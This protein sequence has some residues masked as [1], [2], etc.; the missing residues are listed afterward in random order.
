MI[1]EKYEII[2]KAGGGGG[3]QI[4]QVYD[5]KLEKFW[6]AKRIRKDAGS[7]EERILQSAD[8]PA[9]ARIVDMV[10]EAEWKYLIMDWIEG[11]SLQQRIDR[12]G[13]LPV[14][15]AVQ[16]GIAVCSAIEQLHMMEPPVLYL[17]CKPANIMLGKDGRT[18]LV[19]FGSAVQKNGNQAVPMAGSIGYTAPE[20]RRADPKQ[21]CVDERSDIYGLGKTLYAALGGQCPDRPPYGVLPLK[22]VNGAVPAGLCRV[23]E[24]SISAEPRRR[25]QTMAALSDAL[26]GYERTQRYRKW[27]WQGM[28][29]VFLLLILGAAWELA[30]WMQAVRAGL[31]SG[32][33]WFK[34]LFWM[35]AAFGWNRL[36]RV[37]FGGGGP[38]W[39][40]KQNVLRT[41]KKQGIRCVLTGLLGMLILGLIPFGESSAKE[42]CESKTASFA[43]RD[44]KMRK[45]LVKEGT[46]LEAANCIYIELDP[47]RFSKEQI[48]TIRISGKDGQGK[49][50]E[51]TFLY[52]PD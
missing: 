9:F 40:V 19:D 35:L 11:E 18:W 12:R 49:E 32:Y 34:S 45:L 39:E 27:L 44:E 38:K 22:R 33:I 31:E 29:T 46:V 15:E 30:G 17:D 24:K 51:M 3:G 43:L 16:V 6:A 2:N 52:Q 41:L 37:C 1:G 42:A 21:R 13:T 23:V 28:G 26:E 50:T 5:R 10:E 7:M 8:F 47:E 20:Q 48:Y 4:F 14:L 36:M 25:Y